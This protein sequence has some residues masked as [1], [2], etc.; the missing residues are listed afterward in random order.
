MS[1]SKN[2]NIEKSNGAFLIKLSEEIDIHKS[3]DDS[4]SQRKQTST[5]SSNSDNFSVNKLCNNGRWTDL[6]HLIF[7]AWIME[8]GRDWKK[9]EFY[10]HTRSSSQAR[11]HA[12][13][14]LKKLDK[15]SILKEISDLK[16]KINFQ[17]VEHKWEGLL[18]LNDSQ[19]DSLRY[20]KC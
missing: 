1:S 14:V 19:A 20:L 11:S 18:F 4:P 8:F 9:I 2:S 12:Q 3:G 13:K 5:N 10:V 16:Y 15:S 17:P 7:L 6:E